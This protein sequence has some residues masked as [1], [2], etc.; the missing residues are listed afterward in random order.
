MVWILVLVALLVLIA[1]VLLL[2]VDI[3][4]KY[5][6]VRSDDR[7]SVEVRTLLGLVLLR[8]ELTKLSSDVTSSGPAVRAEAGPPDQPKSEG[9]F[10]AT[11]V[12]KLAENFRSL[13]H[14]VK[15]SVHIA[16]ET[17]RHVRV[18]ELRVEANVG[19]ADTVNT[20]ITVGVMYALLETAF[21]WLSYQ[22]RF[23]GPPSVQV[24]PV[25][26]ERAFSVR[27]KGILRIRMGHAITAGIRL[28]FAWKRRTS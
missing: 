23:D 13:W 25:F 11:E 22:C 27:T 26:N 21:G 1:I 20:G 9:D 4:V 14:F 24:Q 16:R 5:E 2:P 6:R 17:L 15:E 19:L 7:G 8:R 12:P 28:L 10:S 3:Y 18:R